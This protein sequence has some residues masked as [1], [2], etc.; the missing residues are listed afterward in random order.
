[1]LI[2]GIRVIVEDKVLDRHD[3][4]RQLAAELSSAHPVDDPRDQV[5]SVDVELRLL[6]NDVNRCEP[7]PRDQRVPRDLLSLQK[8]LAMASTELKRLH[9]RTVQNRDVGDGDV[10]RLLVP[11]DDERR[12]FQSP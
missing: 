12:R 11:L 10:R 7:N 5:S 1:M 8:A 2:H 9:R 4:P 6:V 3:S